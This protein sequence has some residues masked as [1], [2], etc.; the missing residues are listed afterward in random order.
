MAT[1]ILQHVEPGAPGAARLLQ[2]FLRRIDRYAELRDYPA[3][4]GPSHLSVHLRFGTV[5]V[6]E[7]ARAAH[8]RMRAESHVSVTRRGPTGVDETTD[9]VLAPTDREV[10]H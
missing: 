8:E 2:H 9:K 4:K 7:L 3:A 10:E 6:R 1:N 5:S